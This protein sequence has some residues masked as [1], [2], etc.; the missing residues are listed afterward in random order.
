MAHIFLE[1]L[2]NSLENCISELEEIHS[3]FCQNP[4]SDFTRRLGFPVPFFLPEMPCL[5]R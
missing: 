1:D 2:K 3:L 4:E 5:V